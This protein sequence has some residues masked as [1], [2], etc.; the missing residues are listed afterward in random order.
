MKNLMV[1]LLVAAA[2]C[3]SASVWAQVT[4][5]GQPPGQLRDAQRRAELRRVLQQKQTTEITQRQLNVQQRA[6]LREALRQQRAGE[7]AANAA[8]HAG[9]NP[10]STKP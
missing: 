9:Q 1:F 3:A 8:R 6:E 2:G 5:P 4:G 7:M 10:G